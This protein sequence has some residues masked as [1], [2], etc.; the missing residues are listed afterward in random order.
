MPVQEKGLVRDLGFIEW[1]DPYGDYDDT[2]GQRYKEAAKEEGEIFEKQL[3]VLPEDHKT[4]WLNAFKAL[5]KSYGVYYTSKWHSYTFEIGEHSRLMPSFKVKRDNKTELK[6]TELRTVVITKEFLLSIRDL[7]EGFERLTLDVYDKNLHK[8]LSIKDVADTAAA[9]AL[10]IYYSK[11]ENIYWYNEI[12]ALDIKTKKSR[13]IYKEKDKRYVL[14]IDKP[15]NQEDV[16]V[17]RVCAI[18]Q[19]VGVIRNNKI[20]WLSKGTGTKKALTHNVIAHDG[21]FSKQNKD[22]QY[23]D[24]WKLVDGQKYKDGFLFIFTKDVYHALWSY[25]NSWTQ[26]N[27]KDTVCEIKFSLTADKIIVGY[28]NKPDAVYYLD[29]NADLILEKTID[30]PTYEL[31]CGLTATQVPWFATYPVTDKVKGIVIYGYGSYGMSVRKQ[32]MRLWTPWLKQGFVI[33]NL[34]VRG[35]GENGDNWWD[36]SRTAPRRHVGVTDFVDGVLYLQKTLNFDK[37]NTVIYGRSAGGFLVTAASL[38]LLDKITVVYGA[39]PYTDVLRTTTNLKEPQTLHESEEFGLAYSNPVDFYETLKISPYENIET[40]ETNP[41]V[42]LTAG[43]NDTEVLPY[44]PIKYAKRLRDHKWKN[45]LCRLAK[46]E[47]HFTDQDKEAGE[48]MD[49][50]ICEWF[51][52]ASGQTQAKSVAS[53]RTKLSN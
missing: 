49:G 26:L 38:Q 30:G 7:S 39:K 19:D 21:H 11:A 34:C 23:P 17:K 22:V 31:K 41:V 33:A 36:A 10:D 13:R 2:D 6:M 42:L 16:F 44:M 12:M 25:N 18:H 51:I 20:I 14:K 9:D 52:Q 48:A 50:A 28:P 8:T 5:P 32:Q 4:K 37:T 47:G 43:T 45:V 15:E 40:A 27:N 53:V 3:S 29:D 46:G 1:S 24:G 35:G